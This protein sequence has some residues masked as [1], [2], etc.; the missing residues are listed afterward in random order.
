MTT[1]LIHV[2]ASAGGPPLEQ[3]LA[4][5][6]IHVLGAAERGTLVQD[7]IRLAPDVLVCHDPQPDAAL[8][9]ALQALQTHAPRAILLFSDSADGGLIER[10]VEVGVHAYVVQG[11]SAARLRPLLML[12]QVRFTE[13]Q[14][15]RVALSEVTH[16]FEE[17]KLVD[18]A[19]GLLM[20]ARQMHEDEAFA[21]LRSVAM[22]SGQRI[23]E[24]SRR[25]IDAARGAADVN[26]SGQLRMLSQRIV[27]LQ[28][29]RA[30]KA[31]AAESAALLVD[32]V[33]R[34]DV[35]VQGLVKDLPVATFGDLIDALV[36]AW[37]A[38]QLALQGEPQVGVLARV[39]ALAEA[40]LLQSDRLTAALESAGT[41]TTL[42][43]INVCGRQRMLSQRVAKQ[44]LLA[45]LLPA[46]PARAATMAAAVETQAEY[47]A[48]V[49]WL[50]ALPLADRD[51]RAALAAAD[52]QWQVLLGADA[53]KP[54]GRE[55]LGAA[56]E[57]LLELFDG[58]T[59]H[60]ERSMQVLAA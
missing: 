39:D 21:V 31:R 25:L 16:R 20:R 3:D 22:R 9:D 15:S 57:A 18:R 60:Y 55:G 12:A 36:Q 32:S 10:A 19:K 41:A 11:Y 53:A 59:G 58:L 44:R 46:G 30:A 42:R 2:R 13:Q 54:A 37:T 40:M 33:A 24:V 51:I 43:V 52:A 23:G 7:A 27:K 35:I 28:A 26:R 17:R 38:L 1:A 34:T 56:S 29:L 4:A 45:A 50:E 8:F 49:A 14:A 48:G 47:E 6:G 5:A